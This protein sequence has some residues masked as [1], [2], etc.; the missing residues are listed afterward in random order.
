M[1]HHAENHPYH[2]QGN[3]P[4]WPLDALRRVMR[5]LREARHTQQH[6]LLI[7]AL[8][9]HLPCWQLHLPNAATAWADALPRWIECY[10]AMGGDISTR[11]D[12]TPRDA[13][14]PRACSSR[15]LM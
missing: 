5:L 14:A 12:H 8:R 13:P 9:G 6:G 3:L 15:L 2:L 11:V 7:T 4:S 1:T 10:L